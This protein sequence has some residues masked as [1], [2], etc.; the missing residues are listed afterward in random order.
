[1]AVVG[2]A[3][4]LVETEQDLFQIG[5]DT[6]VK[7]RYLHDNAVVG[8]ARHKRVLHA[9]YHFVAVI[10]I[11]LVADIKH[12]LID[13]ANSVTQNINRHH[14]QGMLLGTLAHHVLLLVVL[15]TKILAEA[16]RLRLNP[17]LLKLYE[18]LLLL[19]VIIA[20]DGGKVDAEHRNV[21]LRHV[22]MLVGALRHRYHLLFEKGGKDGGRHT[23]VL[24]EVFE[25]RVVY[26]VC[27]KVF[28][29]RLSL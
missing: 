13:L 20:N 21:F 15:R 28:H 22:G 27:T 11:R 14:G 3:V 1:M 23:L 26:R 18:Y 10:V 8:E 17:S 5:V 12:R 29:S 19:A 4:G 9:A 2:P 25:H 6:T 24:H 7:Q 16:Q